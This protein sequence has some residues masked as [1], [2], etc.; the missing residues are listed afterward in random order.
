MITAIGMYV[1][2]SHGRALTATPRMRY[3]IHGVSRRC[4]FVFHATATITQNAAGMSGKV[5][6]PVK[7]NGALKNTDTQANAAAAP[8]PVKANTQRH[9]MTAMTA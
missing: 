6:M 3:S 4:G 8:E 5:E 7:K 1:T 9:V 2:D